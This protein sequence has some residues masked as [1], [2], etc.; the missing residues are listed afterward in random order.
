MRRTSVSAQAARANVRLQSGG[1][2]TLDAALAGGSGNVSLL[3]VTA[4]VQN[5]DGD[6]STTG[7]GTIDADGAAITMADG[8]VTSA[9][10]NIRYDATAGAFT[11][12]E[13]NTTAGDVSIVAGSVV[14]AGTA[15][16]TDVDVIGGSLKVD[17]D[18]RFG[19]SNDHIT[20]TV[21]RLSAADS[22][23]DGFYLIE[24]SGLVIGQTAAITVARV[25]SN[26]GT[27]RLRR[28]TARAGRRASGGV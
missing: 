20:T 2:L 1:S 24:T 21:T 7:A 23:A 17:V 15:G 16:N 6:V 3:A 14:D 26:A 19:E 13:L 25:D 18:G 28:R 8:A 27:V 11:I 9:D 12:G 10:A 5:A 22:D 4:L